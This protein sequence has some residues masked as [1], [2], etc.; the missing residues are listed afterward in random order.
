M[1]SRLRASVAWCL[2]AP[3]PRVQ[4]R[5]ALHNHEFPGIAPGEVERGTDVIF[6]GG[7]AE[8]GATD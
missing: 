2:V 1:L 4:T 5:P 3:H 7:C 6:I 8:S